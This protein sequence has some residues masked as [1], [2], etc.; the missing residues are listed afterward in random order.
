MARPE[1]VAI[2]DEL[3]QKLQDSAAAIVTDYRG[4]NVQAI[5]ELRARLREAGVDYRVVKNSLTRF[6]AE[7]ANVSGLDPLLTGPTAIA[8]NESDPV[9]PAKILSEFAK[10]NKAL[11]IKGAVL[12]GSVIDVEAVTQLAD[13]PSREELLGQVLM[14]MQGPIYG[15]ASVLQG[16]LR[17]LVYALDGIRQQKESA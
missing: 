6:A 7:K 10:S 8:F 1:K 15:L 3:A 16:T 12:N 17:G 4:L 2:V 5:T 13:L 11:E 14:R 9:A